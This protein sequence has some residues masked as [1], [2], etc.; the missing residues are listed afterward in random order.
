MSDIH[1]LRLVLAVLMLSGAVGCMSPAGLGKGA[2]QGLPVPHAH[3]GGQGGGGPSRYACR[4][5]AG[6]GESCCCRQEEPRP[7]KPPKKRCNAWGGGAVSFRLPTIQ[8]PG[9]YRVPTI[10]EGLVPFMEPNLVVQQ[11]PQ[12]VQQPVVQ[13]PV[14]PQAVV[15]QAACDPL[16]QQQLIAQLIAMQQAQSRAAQSGAAQTGG[17]S[18]RASSS[19]AGRVSSQSAA[20]REKMNQL[21]QLE[22]MVEKLERAVEEKERRRTIQQQQQQ[23]QQDE[24]SR[25]QQQLRAFPR[26]QP[27][28][29]QRGSSMPMY[30]L[31]SA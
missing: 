26:V 13:Q 28:S 31:P 8:F 24:S 11:P 17:S 30:R 1:S 25:I 6:C 19:D 12:I 3:A 10:A 14:V 5:N 15:Q 9:F 20:L 4:R 29:T 2:P 23:Q 16:L 21:E 22:T 7:P 18:N 27:A